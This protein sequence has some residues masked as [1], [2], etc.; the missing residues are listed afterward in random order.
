MARGKWIQSA[1]DKMERKG[2]LGSFG[3]ATAKNISRGMKAGGLQKKR[4]VFAA[5][6]RKIAARR[7]G[8]S[9]TR[10]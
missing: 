9:A 1:T 4:A 10:R 8:R 3:P 6:M 7:R 5:N 2:T